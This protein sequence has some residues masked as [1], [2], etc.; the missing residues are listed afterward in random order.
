[1]RTANE[2]LNRG[3]I[4]CPLC[5]GAFAVHGSY[6]RHCKDGFDQRHDGWI[7]QVHCSAC[8]KYPSLIPDFIMP[9]KHYKAEVIEAVI[10]ES[11]EGCLD[12]SSCPA[13]ESTMRR[14]A[15]QFKERGARAAGWLLAILFVV[16]RYHVNILEYQNKALLKRLAYLTHQLGLPETFGIIGRVNFVLTRHNCGFL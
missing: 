4:L 9:Y 1:M 15:N 3:D 5:G 12:L 6:K 8:N 16:Y 10:I 13:D 11:E 7:A 14:W 2:M